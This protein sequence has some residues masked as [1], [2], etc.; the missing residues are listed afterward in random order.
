VKHFRIHGKGGKLRHIPAYPGTLERIND[1][2]EASGRAGDPDGA[3][4]RPIQ[5]NVSGQR[6]GALSPQAVYDLVVH[7][8]AKKVGSE[9]APRAVCATH[10]RR[11]QRVRS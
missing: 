11:D 4:F 8:Y 10:D 3:L 5:N 7:Y 1:Y 6:D 9:I 2:L